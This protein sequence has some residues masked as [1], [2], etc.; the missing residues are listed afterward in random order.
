MPDDLAYRHLCLPALR[1]GIDVVRPSTCQLQLTSR[2]QTWWWAATTTLSPLACARPN[3]RR[4]HLRSRCRL[5]AAQELELPVS[6]A[7]HKPHL[8]CSLPS[9]PFQACM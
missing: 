9:P 5:E 1:A 2:P 8:S 6:A 4:S 7:P 3:W